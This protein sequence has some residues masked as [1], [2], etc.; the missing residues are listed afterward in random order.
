MSNQIKEYILLISQYS[1][2]LKDKI[3][4]IEEQNEMHKK[5]NI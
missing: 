5:E 2:D 1:E 4:E 3:K